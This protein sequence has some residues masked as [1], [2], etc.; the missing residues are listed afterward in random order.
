M[1]VG[2]SAIAPAR[3]VATVPRSG[4]RA[5]AES[6]SPDLAN[7]AAGD[8]SFA[9]PAHICAAAVQAAQ[10]G[11]THYTHGRG[12]LELREAFADK[13]AR[14]NGLVDVDPEREIVVTAGALNALAAIFQA[15]LDPGDEALVPDPGLPN[16]GAQVLLAGGRPVPAPL[17][18]SSGWCYDLDGLERRVTPRT[19][20]LVVN[21]PANPTG[22]VLPG[23]HLRALAEFARVHDLIVVSDESY[24]RLVYPPAGHRSFAALPGARERTISVFSVSK[25][26]AMTGWRIGFT[27]APAALS[28]VLLTVQEHLIG[29]PCSVSQA[30]AVAAL[31]GPST[32]VHRMVDEYRR[33]RD[34]VVK[35]LGGLAGVDLVPPAGGLYAFPRVDSLGSDPAAVIAA[36]ARVRVVA[37]EAF[38]EV[39]SGHVRLSFAGKTG[40]LQVALERLRPLLS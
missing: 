37:G 35:V 18:S 32:V 21:S 30:A 23:E 14:E 22:A 25:S 2:V 4:I 11:A 7:L 40:E 26:Y 38:G 3:R 20:L 33:R 5:A 6:L 19:R 16:Y 27:V 12:E 29:C 28:D 17:D 15:L 31:R 39:G 36:R 13:L 34:L 9:T 8:P 1:T 10:H 24:E